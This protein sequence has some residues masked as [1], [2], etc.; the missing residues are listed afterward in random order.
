VPLVLVILLQIS[1]RYGF[2]LS[3]FGGFHGKVVL[4]VDF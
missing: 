2:D 4:R 1:L 3:V